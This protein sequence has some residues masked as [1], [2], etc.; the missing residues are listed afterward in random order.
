MASR[1]TPA[2]PTFTDM[3][4]TASALVLQVLITLNIT[5]PTLGSQLATLVRC[6]LA[7]VPD[8]VA[9]LTV[10]DEA[11]RLLAWAMTAGLLVVRG[12]AATWQW[13]AALAPKGPGQYG[14]SLRALD[15][16][17]R[18]AGPRPGLRMPGMPAQS[19]LVATPCASRVR[20]RR[21]R[22]V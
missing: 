20:K 3:A 6:V 16:A 11:A 17:I 21:G 8:R 12:R 4:M 2:P 10:R 7:D 9:A 22:C 5:P 18:A 14:P 1:R 19:A 13:D 15:R